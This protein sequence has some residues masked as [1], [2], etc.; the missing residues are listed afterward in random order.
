MAS[1]VIQTGDCNAPATYQALMNQLFSLYISWFM[2]V[3][4]DDIVVYLE[5]LEE[6]LEHVKIMLSILEK[7]KL[8]LSKGKL[9]FLADKL[10]ILGHVI[11]SQGIWID[12]DKVDTV[13][14]WKTPTNR[15]LL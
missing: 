9:Q 7:E 8:Y 15:D 3:Y 11:D 14:K 13:V 2:D 5:T 10:H 12:P 6:H 1:Q 4:L